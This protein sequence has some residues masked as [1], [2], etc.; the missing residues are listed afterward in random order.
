MKKN[1]CL[2]DY[3]LIILA[4]A[5]FFVRIFYSSGELTPDSIQYLL[6]AQDFWNYKVNFPLGYPFFIRLGS[7][8]TGN[9]FITSKIINFLSFFLIVVLAKYKNFYPRETL[10]LVCFYPFIN[11]LPTTL[12]EPLFYFFN[13][14][15]IYNIYIITTKGY[16]IKSALSL[17]LLFFF[18]ISVR[19][20]GL[21]IFVAFFVYIL[22]LKSKQKLS[23]KE[24]ISLLGISGLGIFTYL[25]INYLYCGFI[26]GNRSHLE[27]A[28]Q[29]PIKFLS[30]FLLHTFY[31]FSYLNG[32]YHKGLIFYFKSL[33]IWVG[34]AWVSF[35]LI[36]AYK[37]RKTA[38][39]Y[40][41]L[42]SA[43]II[44]LSLIYTYFSTKVDNS[45]RIKSN[46][47]F[48]IFILLLINLSSFSK[49]IMKVIALALLSL[50]IIT[51]L[52]FSEPLKRNKDY[53]STLIN[54]SNSNTINIVYKNDAEKN[55][56]KI[57]LFKALLIDKN[58]K[59]NELLN[60]DITDRSYISSTQIIK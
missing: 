18:L 53:F 59:F 13:A 21:F 55:N 54:Q 52:K 9:Y 56:A 25:G 40:Y 15:I 43:G 17:A 5:F 51:I 47:Y 16:S 35:A 27:V 20:S 22:Y 23:F 57:L 34:A 46:L 38:F 24:C 41:L 37:T 6:Q 44:F 45:I 12:S 42:I 30:D 39:S 1:Y 58:C 33:H 7:F 2:L 36:K 32:I 28:Y 49:N 8:F 60:S 31:D 10:L 50:N 19:F 26:L 3:S 29:N 48:Y 4:I 14:L 11:F